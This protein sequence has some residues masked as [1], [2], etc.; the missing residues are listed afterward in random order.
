MKD[1]LG[2]DIGMMTTHRQL[3]VFHGI[4]SRTQVKSPAN[5]KGKLILSDR[6]L[7]LCDSRCGS[8]VSFGRGKPSDPA[9]LL[10]IIGDHVQLYTL[11]SCIIG[12]HVLHRPV[13]CFRPASQISHAIDN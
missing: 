6:F 9:R 7:G 2:C 5:C 11:I 4:L 12:R 1:L 3:L 13:P 10:P 8:C